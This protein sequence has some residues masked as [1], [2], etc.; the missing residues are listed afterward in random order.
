MQN[1]D[2]VLALYNDG[3]SGVPGAMS[4]Q[5]AHQTLDDFGAI[6]GVQAALEGGLVSR[7]RNRRYVAVHPEWLRGFL[8]LATHPVVT[9]MCE[10][11]LGPEWEICELGFDIPFPGAVDQ[12]WHRDF[13]MPPETWEEGRF[14]SL[15][16]NLTTIDV[17]PEMGP[18]EVAPGTQFDDGAGWSHGMFPAD[19]ARFE[20]LGTKRLPKAGDMS[21]RT[22]LTV[23]RGTANRSALA[24]PVLILGAVEPSVVTAPEHEITVTRAFYESLPAGVRNHLRVTRVVEHLEPVVQQHTIEGLVMGDE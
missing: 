12:P 2:H 23:H 13:P 10:A 21:L 15:A 17:T 8:E 6:Y 5:W 24:R 7:G 11:I 16:F 20:Q 9:G 1:Q 19:T 14:S 4:R 18:F 3:I 22:G